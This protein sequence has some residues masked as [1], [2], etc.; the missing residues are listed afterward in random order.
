MLLLVPF[1]SYLRSNA[2]SGTSSSRSYRPLPPSA[3]ANMPTTGIQISRIL[4][5][6][7]FTYAFLAHDDDSYQVKDEEIR[8]LEPGLSAL[9]VHTLKSCCANGGTVLD[10]GSHFGYYAL[11]GNS[12]GCDFVAIEP[13]PLFRSVLEFNLFLN[14]VKGTVYPYAL[15][16]QNGKLSM[17]V[18]KH[19]VLGTAHVVAEENKKEL[20]L[21]TNFE[22]VTVEQR[23]L[24]ELVKP[25]EMPDVCMMKI[26]VEGFEPA[27]TLAA[28][29][30]LETKKIRHIMMEFSPGYTTDGLLDMLTLFHEVGYSAVEVPW[31]LAKMHSAIPAIASPE[32]V[33][34]IDQ[35]VD[36]STKQSRQAFIDKVKPVFNTNLWL[37]LLPSTKKD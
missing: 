30:L 12:L 6:N 24:D 8:A 23:R 20:A 5:N 29:K 36:I 37:T 3:L 32:E 7:S 28:N 17:Q 9:W 34:R 2:A 27:V 15:G 13:V 16:T 21:D 14:N 10:I 19:G 33:L 22:I 25:S 11:L 35:I 4:T 1:I 26:D 31:G 18:P